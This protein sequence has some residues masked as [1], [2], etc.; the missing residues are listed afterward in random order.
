VLAW[1]RTQPNLKRLPVV[2]MTSPT[3]RADINAAYDQHVNSYLVKPVAFDAFLELL[4]T[5][6]MYWILCNEKP[7]LKAAG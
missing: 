3:E 1:M 6:N 4:K 7:D 5:V 2:I